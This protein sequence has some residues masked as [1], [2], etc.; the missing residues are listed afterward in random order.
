[1]PT[2]W[3]GLLRTLP[4][5][6]E[7]KPYLELGFSMLDPGDSE[8]RIGLLLAK[9]AWG[10]G[11][12]EADRDPARTETYR[13]AAE[14]A[15]EIS[16]RMGRLDLLS[17]ALDT[18]GAVSQEIGGYGLANVYQL[19]R[20]DL[21][22]ELD[23][24]SE[25]A[26]IIGTLAWHYVHIG[27][28]REATE[29]EPTTFTRRF[30]LNLPLLSHRTKLAFNAV[31]LFRMGEWNR[32]WKAFHA[33]DRTIDHG[34]AITYHL[35]RLY[36]VAAYLHDIAGRGAEADRLIDELDRSQATRGDTGVSSARLWIVEVLVRRGRFDLARQRMVVADPSRDR[37]NLDLTYEAWADLLAE[38]GSWAEAPRIIAEARE[39]A[40]H[41]GL[42]GH[43]RVQHF[44]QRSQ[45][46][47]RD[48]LV[49]V[50]SCSVRRRNAAIHP[51]PLM[52]SVHL[53]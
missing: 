22:P 37:Q 20:L 48:T 44:P 16:R 5:R 2:R 32:F 10:W 19:Q 11:F 47:R 25:V 42:L 29:L 43:Q 28:Y 38:E 36:G 17:A 6:E 30:G 8:E 41:G 53:Q 51:S 26:D 4:T 50:A 1:M 18:A 15:I 21:V 27:Q 33:I 9:G 35:M 7:A 52:S 45:V 49:V 34:K 12:G 39:W 3:P 24:P 40:A 46:P 23:D 31:A 14:E 13:A